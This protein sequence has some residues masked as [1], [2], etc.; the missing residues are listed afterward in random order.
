[1]YTRRRVALL[2]VALIALS[3]GAVP[4][5]GGAQAP[6]DFAVHSL[7][8]EYLSNPLGIDVQK[9]RLS[10]MLTP[11]PN[12][13]G[14]SAYRVLVASAPEILRTDR[15]DLWDSGRVASGKPWIEYGGKELVSGQQL[16]KVRAAMR[17]PSPWSTP[18][19]WL[20][21]LQPSEWHR[22]GLASQPGWNCRRHA[23]SIP[24]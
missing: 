23:A 5:V 18:A 14:Q 1:M 8:C 17:Q 21:G 24:G 19:T 3:S 4:R 22:N 9:P 7:R 20:M 10:W 6:T 12:V 15:G 11:A 16:I 2:I 13:R